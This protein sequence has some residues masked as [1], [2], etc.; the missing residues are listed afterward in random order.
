LRIVDGRYKVFF[1]L[2]HAVGINTGHCTGITDPK[3]QG[4]A[5]PVEERADGLIDI[6]VK[7]APALLE[8]SGNAL[9]LFYQYST[10][11]VWI[12]IF[13]IF[14]IYRI[15]FRFLSCAPK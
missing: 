1:N 5:V 11:I 8:F 13:L 3:Q 6:P 4:S 2:L 7:G 9:T 12:S 14:C 15:M 10:E